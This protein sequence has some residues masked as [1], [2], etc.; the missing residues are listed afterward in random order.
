MEVKAHVR[1]VVEMTRS[2]NR[3]GT[4]FE[5]VELVV[6]VAQP[7]SIEEIRVPLE[8]RS[9]VRGLEGQTCLLPIRPSVR[10]GYL[11]FY[12]TGSPQ[13]SKRSDGQKAAATG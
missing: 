10:N 12:L 9:E 2:N 7:L 4:T 8:R 3:D 5:T 13:T 11:N 6:E 1:E